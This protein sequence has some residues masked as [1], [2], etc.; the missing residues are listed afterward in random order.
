[1]LRSS[2][3]RFDLRRNYYHGRYRIKKSVFCESERQRGRAPFMQIMKMSIATLLLVILTM[4]VILFKLVK[5][6]NFWSG[7]GRAGHFLGVYVV[8]SIDKRLIFG[9]GY[10]TI[11]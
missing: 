8:E 10:S 1:M 2:A 3:Q 7:F 6:R 5:F 4:E 9:L 11:G